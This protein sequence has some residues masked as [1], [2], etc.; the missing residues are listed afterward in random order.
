MPCPLNFLYEP[1]LYDYEVLFNNFRNFLTNS[2]CSYHRRYNYRQCHTTSYGQIPFV[3][4]NILAFISIM[5]LELKN[6]NESEG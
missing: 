4:G 6:K 2:Y 3:L 5:N 1:C